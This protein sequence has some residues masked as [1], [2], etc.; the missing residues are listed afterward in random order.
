MSFADSED[1]SWASCNV[2]GSGAQGIERKGQI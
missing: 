2:S 1:L